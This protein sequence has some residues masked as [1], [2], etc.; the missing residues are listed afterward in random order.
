MYC[1]G[2]VLPWR[3][4]S[5]ELDEL[6]IR[7]L[8]TIRALA[9]YSEMGRQDL[10]LSGEYLR[11]RCC[12]LVRIGD[13]GMQVKFEHTTATDFPSFTS[14]K[15]GTVSASAGGSFSSALR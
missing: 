7:A 11:Q 14:G 5:C 9:S 2:S 10:R 15:L 4:I 6:M 1:S 13:G 8:Q 12:Q 3:S